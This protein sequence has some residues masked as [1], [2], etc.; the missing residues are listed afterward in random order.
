MGTGKPRKAGIWSKIGGGSLMFAAL[1]HIILLILGAFWVFQITRP[2]EKKVDF[3]PSGA[4]GGGERGTE[5]QVQQKKRAQITPTTS[6]KRVFAEGA[7]A[8]YAIPEQS[9]NFGEMSTLSSLSGGGMSGGLGGSGSGKGFGKGSGI[10]AGLVQGAG[11]LTPFGIIDPKAGSRGLEGSLYDAKQTREHKATDIDPDG[12]AELLRD[13]TEHSWSQRSL[14]SKCFQADRKL[15]LAQVCMPL[16]AAQEAPKAFECQDQV[17]PSRW[18]IVYHGTVTAPKTGKFRFVGA[19][20]DALVVRFNRQNVFDHGF[21][22]GTTGLRRGNREQVV[23]YQ[24]PNS[25]HYNGS[26]GGYE[27]GTEFFVKAG[28][29]Y[30]IEILIS[31]IPGGYFGAVLLIQETGVEYPKTDTGAPLLPLFRVNDGVPPSKG[32]NIPPFDPAG[33]VWKVTGEDAKPDL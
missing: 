9:D 10:G 32:D 11:T 24:Y 1:F 29:N 3:M 5:H 27:A 26:I 28:T 17:Q 2:P 31:E 19:S 12:M 25:P 33:P 20:D 23:K 22:K 15:Y 18:L 6:V 30:P 7:T 8:S 13:F 14:A 21:S 4:A 16:M